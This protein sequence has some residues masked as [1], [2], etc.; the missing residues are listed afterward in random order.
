MYA[1]KSIDCVSWRT[2]LCHEF[3]FLLCTSSPLLPPPSLAYPGTQ[4]VLGAVERFYPFRHVTQSTSPT[5]EEGFVTSPESVC[6]GLVS[7]V[8]P[9]MAACVACYISCES[10]C[11]CFIKVR[12]SIR[13][14]SQLCQAKLHITKSPLR[15]QRMKK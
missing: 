4:P 12:E 3:Y 11:R 9:V 1:S 2:F 10:C 13:M 14:L 15:S 7:S 5:K 8:I 6:E